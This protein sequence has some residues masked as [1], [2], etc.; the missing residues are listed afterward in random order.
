MTLTVEVHD[1]EI[2]KDWLAHDRE[3]LQDR[4]VNNPEIF[5]HLLVQDL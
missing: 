5:K 2:L 4:H 3:I 1:L